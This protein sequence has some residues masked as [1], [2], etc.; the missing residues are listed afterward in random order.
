MM[1]EV[2]NF[3]FLVVKN[4][5]VINDLQAYNVFACLKPQSNIFMKLT[6]EQFAILKI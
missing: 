5:A 4:R 3:I 6:T 2:I 1:L